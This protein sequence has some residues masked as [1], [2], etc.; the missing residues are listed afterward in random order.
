MGIIFAKRGIT[1]D[2]VVPRAAFRPFG[3]DSF[4]I[5]ETLTPYRAQFISRAEA[6][7]D[8]PY[9][10]LDASVYMQYIRNG[11]RS[12]Y[13][14]LYFGRRNMLTTFAMAELAE[15]KGRF[16]DKVI[17]GMWHIMEES[18]WI[19][20]AHN[21]SGK[22]VT[23]G[24]VSL[25]DTFSSEDEGDDMKH[26]DL[27]SA[28]TGGQMAW[29][30]YLTEDLLDRE[31]PV[32]R[33]RLLSQLRQRILHPFYTYDHDW[34]M[35]EKGNTL[36][37]W[38][39][40]IVS[41]IL[42]VIALCE[43]DTEQRRAGVAKCLTILDRYTAG[44]PDDGGCDEGPGY[45]GVAG[46]SLFDCLE[47]LSDLSGGAIDVF[48]EPL[49]RR[50]CEYIMNVSIKGE[51]YINFAD[52]SSRPNPDFRMISRMGR[53]LSSPRLAAFAS[54]IVR[55][56]D[57]CNLADAQSYRFYAN[58][59]EPIPEK[60]DYT[61]AHC[62]FFP[63]LQVAVT[64]DPGG[65]FLALKGGS[66]GES[67]NHNDVGQFI[68]F[69]G[70]TP[71]FLDAG[72]EQYCKDTFS[73]KRYTL[74][75]MRGRYH[76]IAEFNGAEQK[77]GGNFR[78]ETV[79]YDEQS[80]K[81]TLELKNAHPAEADIASYKR[82]AMLENGVVTVVDDI[83]LNA[84]GQVELRYL[85]P[86]EPTITGSMVTFRS[87]HKA[88]FDDSLAVTVDAVDLGGGKI[89]REWRRETMYRITLSAK[90][91]VKDAVYTM[92]VSRA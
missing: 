57:I 46:G 20:P 51:L 79:S 24:V 18:T 88:V 11:N 90:K 76:N 16:T 80:G 7:L 5:R 2:T 26:I 21:W 83:C 63:D 6:M 74:W 61:P 65:M 73:E 70:D 17:D 49:V 75:A 34:W 50:F 81:L 69:D 60:Q 13:E 27:F 12:N 54:T 29:L 62:T 15:G 68:L 78:A 38:T 58:L 43:D 71:I 67:H 10:M 39:P 86:D 32:I 45:W 84:P 36:N 85:T 64:R 14:G 22:P 87:G 3:R 19:L 40:W 41:N 35:G 72:V 37:N 30:W 53:R 4:D 42:T 28:G 55:S 25:P 92:T 33:R 47:L 89:A 59:A 44:L 23:G 66:N 9:P 1:A 8:K 31:N 48:D 82:S 77:P 91:P 52:A 56:P